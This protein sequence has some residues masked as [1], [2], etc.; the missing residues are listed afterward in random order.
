MSMP[1]PKYRHVTTSTGSAEINH[2]TQEQCITA[3]PET[4]DVTRVTYLIRCDV[5]LSQLLGSNFD[6]RAGQ[7]NLE[8]LLSTTAIQETG[9]VHR[10]M[11]LLRGDVVL[12]RPPGSNLVEIRARGDIRGD[13][14]GNPGT[15]RGRTGIQETGQVQRGSGDPPESILYRHGAQGNPGTVIGTT[16]I[17]ETGDVHRVMCLIRGDVVLNEPPGLH[18]DGRAGQGNIRT[19]LDHCEVWQVL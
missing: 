12:N 15:V 19:V 13:Q 18:L 8:T 11:S 6:R 2:S 7:G 4:G 3:I 14:S 16:A 1:E 17:Q 9:D 5:V 10:V